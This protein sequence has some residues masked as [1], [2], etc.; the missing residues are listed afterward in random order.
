MKARTIIRVEITEVRA[1]RVQVT[2]VKA[3]RVQV[4]KVKAIRVQTINIFK[5]FRILPILGQR[6]ASKRD[7][8]ESRNP[9]SY[10]ERSRRKGKTNVWDRGFA[11]TRKFN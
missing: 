1:I 2:E 9:N 10:S 8:R 3:V 5:G 4:T 11:E 6:R 7:E